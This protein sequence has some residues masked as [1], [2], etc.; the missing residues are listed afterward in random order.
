MK[1]AHDGNVGNDDDAK[2]FD[3]K[4][5]KRHRIDGGG[6][7]SVSTR[8]ESDIEAGE[9]MAIGRG[10]HHGWS[11]LEGDNEEGMTLSQNTSGQSGTRLFSPSAIT[12]EH[13]T[14]A[15]KRST[16]DEIRIEMNET[17]P[18]RPGTAGPSADDGDAGVAAGESTVVYKVYKRRWFGL[19]QLTLLNIIVSWDWLTFSPVAGHAARYFNT[20]ETTINW[21]ST[22]FMFA[23]AFITPVVIYV[24]H[25]GP[26]HS[27][28]TSAALIL[29]G[30]WIRY[31]GSYSDSES[32]GKFGVVMFGQILTGLAQPFV[33]AAPSRYSDIWFTS[34]G[35]VAATALTSLA[36]PFG[37]ALGQLIV[38]FWVTKPSEVSSMVLWV[39]IIATV[40]S[41]PAFFVPARPP[42]PVAPSSKTP[43]LSIR[44][45]AKILFSS[46]EFYM[47][48][49]PFAI[50]VGLFNSISSLLNQILLPYGYNDEEAGIAGAVLIVVGLVASAAVSPLIDRYKSYLLAI[51]V[52]VPLIGISY[53]VFIWMPQTKDSA[54]VGGPYV[55]MAVLGASSFSLLP[56]VLEYL[57]ELTHPISPEVTSTLAWSGGQVLGGIFIVISGALKAGEGASPPFNMQKAL[58]FSA[59]MGLVAVPLPL[60][61][62]LFGRQGKLELRRIRSDE[63]D[64]RSAENS[65]GAAEAGE[66][67]K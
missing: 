16:S 27:I 62:G 14:D 28:V 58:I 65:G 30:N 42:T 11:R 25:M 13:H 3:D 61:L 53:L 44:A 8:S 36:N 63:E 60:C 52:A 18:Q 21:L 38:P 41:L 29:I 46:A 19:I 45:S 39:S 37:A 17:T 15:T 34:R 50:Y 57:I 26:K 67:G 66:V 5:I 40:G 43:K 12:H 24:L 2:Q 22:A 35:R 6:D 55:V 59:V 64:R 9:A 51:R 48:F 54:G 20:D 31:A 1:M 47:L 4:K 23:F 32:G 33:L 49:I 7:D 10:A 56:V